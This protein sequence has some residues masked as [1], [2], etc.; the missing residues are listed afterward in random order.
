MLARVTVSNGVAFAP[1]GGRA[2]YGDTVTQRIDVFDVVEGDLRGRR[3]FVTIPGEQ[4]PRV[5]GMPV[6]AFAG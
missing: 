2:Y 5:H 4:G 3:G 1:G 6:G